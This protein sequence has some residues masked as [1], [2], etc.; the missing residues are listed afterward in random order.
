MQDQEEKMAKAI[1]SLKHNFATVRTGRANPEILNNVKVDAY[2][3]S[4]P[5]NQVATIH[6]QES[7]T[8]VVTPFD[9]G[10][11]ADVERGIMKA[12]LG[13]TPNNDGVNIRITIPALTEDR[14]KELDKVIKRMAEEGKVAVRNIRRDCMDKAKHD[15]ELSEDEKKRNE[16][17]IQK[18]TDKFIH[19]IEELLKE[20]EAEIM[21]I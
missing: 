10:T 12:D 8:L 7:T 19:K 5:I 13:L 16:H 2:G 21:E 14:R 18:V 15:D 6:V 4:M 1:E 9:K 3:S 17:D 20:K 11:L